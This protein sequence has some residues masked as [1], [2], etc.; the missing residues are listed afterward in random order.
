MEPELTYG[1]PLPPF[2]IRRSPCYVLNQAEPR[3][4]NDWE[5]R[6][7]VD[8]NDPAP[9]PLVLKMVGK[10]SYIS[11]GVDL[12][13]QTIVLTA[14]VGVFAQS[15]KTT[16][17]ALEMILDS[18]QHAI[19]IPKVV[20]GWAVGDFWPSLR[21][22]FVVTTPDTIF[23]SLDLHRTPHVPYAEPLCQPLEKDA[24]VHVEAKMLRRDRRILGGY[25]WE[26]EWRL[27]ALVVRRLYQSHEREYRA[28]AQ[29][30][31]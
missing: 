7:F 13:A 8:V 31:D 4:D 28:P 23:T 5:E 21:K 18:S 27:E 29:A 1:L 17:D 26:T 15:F 19:Y 12:G 9:G 24:Y 14:P 10:A 25:A 16:V 3:L 20:T 6:Y 22:I 30:N 11:S 2:H